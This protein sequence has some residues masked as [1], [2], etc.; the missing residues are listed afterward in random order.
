MEFGQYLASQRKWKAQ[1]NIPNPAADEMVEEI[2]KHLKTVASWLNGY[3][4]RDAMLD[5]MKF[6]TRMFPGQYEAT[7]G[8]IVWRGQSKESFDGTPRSYT[9]DESTADDFACG[10]YPLTFGQIFHSEAL[11]VRRKVTKHGGDK[12]AF[13]FS[14]DIAKLLKAYANHKYAGEKEVVI[15]NAPLRGDAQLMEVEC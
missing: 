4:H 12:A 9:Y 3:M 13:R 10:L 1:V 7:P 5:A 2:Q 6:F 11:V 8:R 14:L 15:L